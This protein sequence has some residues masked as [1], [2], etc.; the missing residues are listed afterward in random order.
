MEKNTRNILY[1]IESVYM[2]DIQ[3]IGSLNN[4]YLI[5]FSFISNSVY[6]TVNSSYVIA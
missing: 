4:L 6:I 5:L 2:L 1:L 3:Y